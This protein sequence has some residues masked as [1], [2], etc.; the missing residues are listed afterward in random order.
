M[1][2]LLLLAL[3]LLLLPCCTS[4]TRLD[5]PAEFFGLRSKVAYKMLIES[6]KDADDC[7]ELQLLRL[8]NEQLAKELEDCEGTEPAPRGVTAPVQIEVAPVKLKL[9]PEKE[10]SASF[11]APSARVSRLGF[12]PGVGGG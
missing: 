7:V 6:D 5:D 3:L 11:P 1:L 2:R 4:A 12:G 10:S 9:V 8:K